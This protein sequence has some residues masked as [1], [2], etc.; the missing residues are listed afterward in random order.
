MPKNSFGAAAKL[1][2]GAAD[3]EIFRLT[4]LEE[5]GVGT[6][7]R[8]PF[9]TKIL[10]E[11]LLRNEDGKRVSADDVSY[12]ARGDFGGDG[13]VIQPKEISFMPA[14]VLLQDFTGVPCVVDLAAMRDALAVMGSD[15]ERAN[16]LMPAD[17]V[18]DHSVQVDQFG[19]KDAFAFNAQLEFQRNRERYMLLRWGQTA[20]RNF[21]V[22]PPDTGIVHQVNLEYLAPVVFRNGGQAYPDS[23]VGTDSHTT[24]INGLG[25]LGWGVGGIEAEACMLGQP[26]SM[27]LP[28]VVGF[29][30]HGKM[31]EGCT[32]TDL[33]LTIT[34]MLRK[35]GVVGKFVEF[36]GAGLSALSVADRATVAN[37]SPEYGATMGFFPVDSETLEY[38]RFTNRD[39]ALIA[40]VEA[41][42]KEQGLFRTDATPDPQYADTLELDLAKVNPSM[43]GPKRP[44]DRVELPGVRANFHAAFTGANGG[45]ANGGGAEGSSVKGCRADQL[46]N[47]SVVIAAIT[48]CTNTSNPSVMLAAG[49]LAKKAVEK[50][51][52][53][54]PWVKTSLAPGSKVVADYYEKA[55]LTAYLEQLNFHLV[56]FGCTTWWRP[57]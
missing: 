22:V 21:R 18:I 50:G 10:L 52:T 57:C 33:V 55:G 51:L 17:L 31:N 37:M 5:S 11:N 32:A 29:K 9:S 14:R 34:Q 24:M 4:R 49:L 25:V 1:R 54:K 20:F 43:A 23:L 46:S 45:A 30:L 26:V 41:Y 12:V 15:P 38:L 42:T 16:P 8:L 40:L 27:L 6:V 36:Y 56:G 28:P 48:S 2:S 19:T 3:Y 35:K 7:S 44:Q 13:S 47:G 39:A 53:V